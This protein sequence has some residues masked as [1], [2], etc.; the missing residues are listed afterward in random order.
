MTTYFELVLDE[1]ARAMD[2]FHHPYAHAATRGVEFRSRRLGPE[3][4]PDAA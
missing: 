3:V 1:H 2:V 4:L